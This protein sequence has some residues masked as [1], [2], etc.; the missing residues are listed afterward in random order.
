MKSTIE[1][2][3][4]RNA[5]SVPYLS[6]KL[7]LSLS[8][9]RFMISGV[10]VQLCVHALYNLVNEIDWQRMQKDDLSTAR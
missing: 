8:L 9:Q 2:G 10:N 1:K 5:R 3:P 7:S 6:H 4:P